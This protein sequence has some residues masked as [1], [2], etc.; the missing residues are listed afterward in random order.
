MKLYQ[1]QLSTREGI[2]ETGEIFA[3]SI[4]NAR[5]KLQEKNKIIIS[6][7]EKKRRGLYFWEKTH[8]SFQDKLLF[9]KH[10]ATMIKIGITL[11]EAFQILISQTREKGKRNMYQN[12]KERLETG[13]TLSNSLKEYGY[14]FSPVFINMLAVGEESGTLETVLEYLDLQLEKEYELRKKVVSAFVYPAVI[15]G[16]TLMLALGIVV[17][18]MPKMTKIFTSL[19]IELPWITKTL[20]NTSNLLIENPILVTVGSFA[21]IIGMRFIFKIKALKPFFDNLSLHAPVF[22]KL[23]IYSNLARFSRTLNSLLQSGIP[24]IKSLEITSM[25]IT[26]SLYRNAL[27]ASKA[28]VEKG[29]QLGESLEDQPKLFPVM[30]TKMLSIGERT[31]SLEVTTDRIAELYEHNVDNLTKNLSVLLEPLLLIVMGVMV[32]GIALSIILPIY[33]LPN[34]IQK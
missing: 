27:K 15:I 4:E 26:N 32:G 22:G 34:L 23:L 31:G 18:I 24:I 2:K 30:M 11:T 8:L 12:I 13:Q 6:I 25:M 20:I 21:F 33:Q 19:K 1:Y 28:I 5:E 14:I 7:I 9:V 17:F 3:P 10:L 29:G 16:M